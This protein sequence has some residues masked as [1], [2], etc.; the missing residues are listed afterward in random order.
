MNPVIPVLKRSAKYGE[1]MTEMQILEDIR[2]R[3]YV[4]PRK[5]FRDAVKE[6][7]IVKDGKDPFG[8]DL[9]ILPGHPIKRRSAAE[10][11]ADEAYVDNM[12]AE[13]D[14]YV[15]KRATE[16]ARLNPQPPAQIRHND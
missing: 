5:A 15:E 8:E 13:A 14:A 2:S 6:G 16:R 9:W 4:A 12:M 1:T 11:V 3:F 7:L 10:I